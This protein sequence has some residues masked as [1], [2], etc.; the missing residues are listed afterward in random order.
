[1]RYG[2]DFAPVDVPGLS[3]G[4][5]TQRLE[6]PLPTGDKKCEHNL[7]ASYVVQQVPFKDLSIA[8]HHASLST[9]VSTYR[10]SDEHRVIIR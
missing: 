9:E 2:Y 1:M 7:T 6:Y 10:D 4:G 8:L 5:C 3:F